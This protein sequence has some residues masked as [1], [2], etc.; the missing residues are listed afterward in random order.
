MAN[1]MG[2]PDPMNVVA[3]PNAPMATV[4]TPST[5]MIPGAPPPAA[6][7]VSPM[8]APAQQQVDPAQQAQQSH[9]SLIGKTFK[10][11]TGQSTQYS[12]GPDGKLQQTQTPTAPGQFF[13]NV[14]AAALIGGAM[15]EDKARQNEGSP[16]AAAMQGGSAV[17]NRNQQLD[18]Q[19]IAQARADYQDQLRA[20]QNQ[21]EQ[22]TADREAQEA[23]IREQMLKAQIAESNQR[24]LTEASKQ[25]NQ[26][27][28][29]TLAEAER[30]KM[31]EQSYEAV[32]ATPVKTDVVGRE[33]I[34]DFLKNTPG[35]G[36]NYKAVAT[37]VKYTPVKGADGKDHLA[38]ENT[39]SIYKL[40]QPLAITQNQLDKSPKYQA[41]KTENPNA[42]NLVAKNI[43]TGKGQATLP[44][45][46]FL[47]LDKEAD[48]A[49]QKQGAQQ[50]ESLGLEALRTEIEEHKAN[51]NAA[52]ERLGMD[53][54]DKQLKQYELNDRIAVDNGLLAMDNNGVNPVD[55][56]N[57]LSGQP[58]NFAQAAALDKY[59]NA[60]LAAA[61]GAYQKATT[62]ANANPSDPSLQAQVA[63]AE[64]LVGD[65]S[66]DI[67]KF[68]GVRRKLGLTGPL[69]T[70]TAEQL[71]P[72]ITALRGKS[73]DVVDQALKNFNGTDAEKQIIRDALK[74]QQ[75]PT[76]NQDD[77]S[78]LGAVGK[79]I[80]GS[81]GAVAGAE[82]PSRRQ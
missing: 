16:L 58:M 54:I 49:F 35:A 38:W 71:A 23:P 17:I 40:D 3:T 79:A 44:L 64:G 12:V 19:H 4:A 5:G 2:G 57:P 28:E 27:H 13:K 9:D 1:P 46:Q 48:A 75:Q 11:L 63:Q 56:K 37:G 24:Q 55:K 81:F 14:V 41:L 32:G 31:D 61:L 22:A 33:G 51:T 76:A 42:Y 80:L 60:N 34:D 10:A 8:Q 25:E 69:T 62:A 39:Y 78:G 52:R 65:A 36:S 59:Y 68:Q 30:G 73:T 21:R 47:A 66:D 50:K 6:P 15:G 74:A 45:S 7:N 43:A 53:S 67:T 82:L 29:W 72:S 26:T 70:R 20:Q 18:Q 77:A